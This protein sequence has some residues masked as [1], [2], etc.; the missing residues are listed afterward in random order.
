VVAQVVP[1]YARTSV[2]IV[3]EYQGA[4][5]KSLGR[6]DFSFTSLESFIGAKVLV[7]A[8]RRAGANPTREGLMKTLDSMQNFNV[9]GYVVDFSTTNHNGSKFVELTAIGKAGKFAY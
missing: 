9:G 2:Q 3:R 8:I 6:K 1:P 5:E 7:E 4:I